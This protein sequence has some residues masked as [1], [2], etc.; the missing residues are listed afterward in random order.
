MRCL[1]ELSIEAHAFHNSYIEVFVGAVS[2]LG[3]GAFSDCESLRYVD[4]TGSTF[5]LLTAG[6]FFGCSELIDVTLPASLVKIGSGAF[7]GC[8]N[9]DWVHFQ[10]TT[11]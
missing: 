8:R 9:L 10:G 2:S 4:F 3:L 11:A 1:G 6:T 7:K 5:R